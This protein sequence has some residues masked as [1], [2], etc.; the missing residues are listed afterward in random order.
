MIDLL[1]PYILA[2]IPICV[3]VDALGNI[4]LFLALTNNLSKKQ[5]LKVIQESVVTATSLAILFMILGKIILLIL[6]IRV[7]DFQV[8]G[9]ALL[10][11]IST[12]LLLSGKQKGSLLVNGSVDVGIFPLGTPLLTGPAVLTMTLMML[13]SYGPAATFISLI[14]N[15]VIVWVVFK[16][17][18]LLVRM[19]GENGMKAFS[20]I[21]YVILAAIGVMMIRK[22]LV[23]FLQ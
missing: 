20:K 10:F 14:L 23:G 7:S 22:G 18:D 5:K 12:H 15:M 21:I 17:A 11:V 3:A 9:G 13:D 19:I 1:K 4:P 8:A 2:F 6:G 16:Y